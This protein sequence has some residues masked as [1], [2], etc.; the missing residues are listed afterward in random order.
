[1]GQHGGL[2]ILACKLFIVNIVMYMYMYVGK[3]CFF[4]LCD[5]LAI[6]V[7]DQRSIP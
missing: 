2:D 6:L 3:D 4:I 7:A 5:V 1:V